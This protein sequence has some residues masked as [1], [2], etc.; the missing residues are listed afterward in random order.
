MFS[1]DFLF[2]DRF[3]SILFQRIFEIRQIYPQIT[4]SLIPWPTV[5]SPQR[6]P[7]RASATRRDMIRVWMLW[8]PRTVSPCDSASA[9]LFTLF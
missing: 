7:F 8:G 6:K 2:P 1:A 3:P 4:A 9:L 5:S